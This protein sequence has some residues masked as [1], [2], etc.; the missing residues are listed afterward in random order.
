M[1][2]LHAETKL[3][4]FEFVPYFQLLNNELRWDKGCN[5]GILEKK[6][7]GLQKLEKLAYINVVLYSEP[8]VT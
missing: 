2:F 5:P 7:K 1:S 4:H 6:K 8:R 3:L